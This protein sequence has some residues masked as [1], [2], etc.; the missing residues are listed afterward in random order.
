MRIRKITYIRDGKKTQSDK[1]YASWQDSSGRLRR[2]ALFPDR[3]ASQEAAGKIEKLESIRASGDMIPPE[4]SRFIE[5]TT[6]YIREKL[7]EFGVLPQSAIT[8]GKPLADHLADFADALRD[9]GTTDAQAELV[10]VRAG[11]I[12]KLCGFVSWQDI[13]ASRLQ[14]CIGELRK[15][16]PEKRGLSIQTANFY[17][18]ACKQFARWMVKD[19]RA[20][21]SAIGHLDGQNV[22]LDRRHDRR[23]LS[24]DE[25]CRLLNAAA[26]APVR[27]GMTGTER[28]CLYRLAVE[29]GLRAG[30]LRSLTAGSFHLDGDAPTVSIAAAYAKNRREDTLPLRK[31]TAEAIRPFIASKMPAVTVFAMPTCP[32]KTA[33]MFRADLADARKAWLDGCQTQQEREQASESTFLLPLDAAGRHADFH[34]LRHT[35]ISNLAA[36]GVHPKTAQTL[37]RHSTITLTMDRYT[38]VRAAD[39]ADAL[40]VLPNLPDPLSLPQQAL[41]TGTDGQSIQI[42]ATGMLGGIQGETTG[43]SG[44]M[45]V[46][47]STQESPVNTGDSEAEATGFEPVVGLRPLRFSRPVQ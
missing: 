23:A 28:A 38:H 3:K 36:G 32:G 40:S 46:T 45:M 26:A 31:V 8:A 2:L 5:G 18:N 30:E 42:D 47:P 44:Q 29:T 7:A 13:S 19:R 16:T 9:K 21:E 41:A 10:S 20:H 17:L 39:C 27:F 37:A 11:R 15:D 4:L 6:P 33:D 34:S 22:K 25:L 43:T 12:F 24:A 14:A 35:F 1:W